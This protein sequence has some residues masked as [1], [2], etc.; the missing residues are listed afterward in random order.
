VKALNLPPH[1]PNDKNGTVADKAHPKAGGV[2]GKDR[3]S[4]TVVAT[5][6]DRPDLYSEQGSA[7]L[8]TASS[9]RCSSRIM[10]AIF[11][12]TN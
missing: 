3:P 6:A 2:L 11:S 5:T 7:S 4:P 12:T 10:S 8:R 1:D 9:R